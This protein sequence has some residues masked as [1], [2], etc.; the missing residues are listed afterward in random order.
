MSHCHRPGGPAPGG[1]DL[2][3]TPLLSTMNLI[4]VT[5]TQGD[6]GI[7]GAQRIRVGSKEQSMV[8]HRVQ[9]TDLG[10]HMPRGARLPDP[11]AVSVLGSWIDTGLTVQDS[12]FDSR[13]DSTDNCPYEPNP[14]QSDG[15]SWLSAVP[16]GNGDACQCGNVDSIGVVRA[17]DMFL[18]RKLLAGVSTGTVPPV[19]RR[20]SFTDSAGRPSIL[21]VAHFWRA[22]V[23]VDPILAQTCPAATQLLP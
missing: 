6:F 1:L 7:V 23:G 12:D 9:S 20:L 13:P 10:I 14:T 5:P 8:W 3:H 4:G 21:D 15:G 11:L 17:S 22:L 19:G 18:L 2:R 16:D